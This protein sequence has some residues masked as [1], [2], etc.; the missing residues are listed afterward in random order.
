MEID[1]S[2]VLYLAVGGDGVKK[3]T[4]AGTF[5]L[6]KVHYKVDERRGL[7]Q[8]LVITAGDR[9]TVANLAGETL[10]EPTRPATGI[11]PV[12]PIPPRAPRPTADTP[13]PTGGGGRLRAFGSALRLSRPLSP[14]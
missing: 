8:V 3:L 10:S 11:R 5:Y 12:R 9:I 4:T 7:Q 2:D 1:S 6:D 14:P 13:P